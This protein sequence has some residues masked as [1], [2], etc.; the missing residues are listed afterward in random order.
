MGCS[1][2]FNGLRRQRV[3]TANT[4]KNVQSG[5]H[6]LEAKLDEHPWFLAGLS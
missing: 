5:L 1:V 4:F 6:D 3:E 2:G